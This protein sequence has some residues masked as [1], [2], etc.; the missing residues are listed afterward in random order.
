MPTIATTVAAIMSEA[1]NHSGN[2]VWISLERAS[3]W[4][5]KSSIVLAFSLFIG[6]ICTVIII[7]TGIAKEHHWD[8]AR[9]KSGNEIARLSPRRLS[10]EQ[11]AKMTPLLVAP[12]LPNLPI[13][14]VSRHNDGESVDFANDLAKV[15]SAAGWE[16]HRLYDWTGLD[17]GV[18]IATFAGTPLTKDVEAILRGAL[19]AA[20]I[21]HDTM[22]VSNINQRTIP[23][24]FQP[25]T[26]YLIVGTKPF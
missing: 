23:Q 15:L 19:E 6:F 13:G 16:P 11:T 14:V 21:E 4:F 17:K 12:N 10:T 8:L 24:G 2:E 5:D 22:T 9:E 1:A 26:L 7:V 25:K 18:F 3:W 20:Q